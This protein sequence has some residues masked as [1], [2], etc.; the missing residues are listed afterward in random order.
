MTYIVELI[1]SGIFG[2]GALLFAGLIVLFMFV[3]RHDRLASFRQQRTA[4]NDLANMMILLQTMR[5]LLEQQ[6]GMARQFNAHLEKRAAD[7]KRELDS[8]LLECDRLHESVKSL[9]S[10]LSAIDEQVVA[11]PPRPSVEPAHPSNTIPMPQAEHKRPQLHEIERPALRILA[12]PREVPD[13]DDRIE[14]WVGLDFGGDVPDPLAFDVPDVTPQKPV[15]AESAREAFRALLNME[16]SSSA[17][18]KSHEEEPARESGNGRTRLSPL[19]ASVYEYS[20]AGMSLAEIAHELG[21]G[22]GEVKLIL[23]LR[24]DR[25]Q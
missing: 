12:K 25:D 23:S 21:I 10:R 11:L 20:D 16:S 4:R 14:N 3:Y 5:D 2:L 1:Y 13:S 19:Q 7:L 17:P 8:A 9:E 6:K 15:D 24:K 22:K 18:E